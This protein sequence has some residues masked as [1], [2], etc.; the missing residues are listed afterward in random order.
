[1]N[2]GAKGVPLSTCTVALNF[3][4][5]LRQLLVTR[6]SA[7]ASLKYAS[8]DHFVGVSRS[9]GSRPAVAEGSNLPGFIR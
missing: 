9:S 7:L 3:P 2:R 4:E 6:C 5:R 8:Q 1:M